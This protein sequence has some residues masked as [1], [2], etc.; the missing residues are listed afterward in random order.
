[1]ASKGTA[2][3]NVTSSGNGS[4]IVVASGP[5]CAAVRAVGKSARR[6]LPPDTHETEPRAASQPTMNSHTRARASGDGRG[7]FL[8]CASCCFGCGRDAASRPTRPHATQVKGAWSPPRTSSCCARSGHGTQVV[9]RPGTSQAADKLV[10]GAQPAEPRHQQAALDGRR[11]KV[12]LRVRRGRAL[13]RHRPARRG[14][15]CAVQNRWNCSCGGRSQFVLMRPAQG[16]GPGRARR[17]DGGP[18]AP[19]ATTVD[20]A[21]AVVTKSAPPARVRRAALVRAT[22]AARGCPGS[23]PGRRRRRILPVRSRATLLP[24]VQ[25]PQA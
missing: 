7:I 13:G 5:T 14:T 16:D 20:R 24:R 18:P 3:R 9:V 21:V 15:G 10:A 8:A 1:M 4:A 12:I 23:S 11:G 17:V 25:V 22:E 6:L 2:K 19:T